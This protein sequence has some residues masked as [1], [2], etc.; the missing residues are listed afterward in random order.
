V[1]TTYMAKSGD[2]NRKWYVVDATGKPLGRLATLVATILRGKHKPTFTPHV[3]TGDHVVVVN[4][5]KVVLTGRKP[6]QKIWHRHTMRPG[7]LKATPYGELL[8]DRPEKAIEIAVRGMLPHNRLGR[9]MLRKLRVYRG[10][11]HPHEAQ[12]P[13]VFRGFERGE[14]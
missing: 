9:S 4:A 8:K 11:V 5:E 13:E 12:K 14:V 10:G 3:D 7:G 1:K 6:K 2:I